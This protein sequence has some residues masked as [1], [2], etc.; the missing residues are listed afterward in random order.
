MKSYLTYANE[1]GK[2]ALA[3]DT[4]AGTYLVQM[5]GG[6]GGPSTEALFTVD[7]RPVTL[8]LP[9]QQGSEG[10]DAVKPKLGEL[11]VASGS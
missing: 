7:P 6:E 5:Q 4:P 1:G 11:A 10:T 2:Y 3:D 8:Q 9:N